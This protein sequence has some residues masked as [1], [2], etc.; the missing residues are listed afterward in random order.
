VKRLAELVKILFEEQIRTE[1]RF[2]QIRKESAER[3][4]KSASTSASKKLVSAIGELI[5]RLPPSAPK[6]S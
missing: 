5:S 3:A 1:K 6:A 2:Q 4:R